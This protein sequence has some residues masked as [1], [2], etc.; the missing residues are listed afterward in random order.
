[1]P[2]YEYQCKTCDQVHEIMQKFSDAPLSECPECKGPVEKLMSL[3]SFALKGSGWY[4]TD[5]K[6]T[7]SAPKKSD[8]PA[9]G[10]SGG[11]CAGCPSAT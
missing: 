10:A 3:G 9:C 5:Y 1:M 8:A 2:L 6:R 7:S 4:T 11:G